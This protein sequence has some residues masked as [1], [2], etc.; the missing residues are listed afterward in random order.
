MAGGVAR[1]KLGLY[2][3]EEGQ[4]VRVEELGHLRKP[5]GLE[6]EMSNQAAD[7]QT[8][9]SFWEARMIA[10]NSETFSPAWPLSSVIE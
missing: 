8:E 7:P 10:G 2:R 6:F 5:G 9:W 1:P 4:W 3:N